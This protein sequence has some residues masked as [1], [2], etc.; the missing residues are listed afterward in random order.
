MLVLWR[1]LAVRTQQKA[2]RRIIMKNEMFSSGNSITITTTTT[3][4]SESTNKIVEFELSVDFA[5]LL[6]VYYVFGIDKI[7]YGNVAH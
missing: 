2:T 7:V 5:F 4:I 3:T 6:V 1:K